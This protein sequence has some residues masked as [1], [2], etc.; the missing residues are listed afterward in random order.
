MLPPLQGA[1]PAG[2]WTARTVAGTG[3]K[4]HSGDSGPALRARLDNPFGVTRGPDGA[5][6]VVEFDGNVVRRIATDGTITTVAGS[7]RKGGAGDGGSALD[8]EFDQP[9]EIRFDRHGHLFIADMLNHRIRKVDAKTRIVSTVA[10]T[11]RPG[12]DGDGGPATRASLHQPIA[13]QFDAAGDL[14]VCDI[15]NHRVRRI[16]TTTGHIDTVAGSGVR[17]TTEDGAAYASAPFHGPRTLDFDARGD[18]WLALREGN[19]VWK[20]D[21]KVGTARLIA[22]NGQKG[23]GGNGGPARLATLSGPKGLSVGP[24]GRVFVADTESHSV[25]VID[26]VSGRIDAVAGDGTRGDGPDGRGNACRLARPHGVFA[27]RDGSVFVGDSENHQ[28]RRLQPA[29]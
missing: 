9:H 11:G 27:D 26:P 13:L 24:D 22:G 8:A 21:R 25:R 1:E 14:F 4:G 12:F 19:Q 2:G 5:L 17:G 29:P 23:M 6:Y 16:D 7:G 15:G 18:L 3:D 20:L 28:V 10:G